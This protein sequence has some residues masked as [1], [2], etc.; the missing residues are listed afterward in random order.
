MTTV[1]E[2]NGSFAIHLLKTLCQNNPSKNVC[3]SPV[4]ISS[5][6]AMVL[7][8]AKGDTAA[9]ITQILGLNTEK[10]IHQGFQWLLNNLNKP[11]RKYI[12]RMANRIFAEV[13][14]ELPPAFKESCLQFYH[15]ET[16]QL[17]FVKAPEES[18]EHIN[19][20]V[21]K[22][23]E[24][25]IPELLSGD[26]IN[27]NTRMVLVNALYFK[28]R[29][30]QSFTKTLTKEMPFKINQKEKQPV[31]MMRQKDTFHLAYVNEVQAQVLLMPYEGMELS[32]VVLLP[33]DGVDLSKVENS[34]TFEKLTAWT[35]PYFMKSTDVEVFLPKFK[36]QEDYDMGSVLQRLTM[37]NVFQE[38]K[39]DLSGMSPEKDLCLSQ[40]IHKSVVE[41]NEEGT[42][43]AA[44]SATISVDCA[45][46]RHVSTFCAD[47]P[48]LFF[49]RHKETNSLLFC[50]R[51]SSP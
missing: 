35:R 17:S 40:F 47:H 7:L 30:Q 16:E 45:D 13:A 15:S 36:L 32:M 28:G 5:A 43:A 39:A 8:G 48:F 11:D 1:C 14:C 51:F 24:G 42:E 34:L 2:A 9:Q 37:M 6:L 25:K 41:V 12:L 44:A 10:D 4:S 38:D 22:Q 46:I 31:Q 20:W 29:W 26:S 27:S 49:I 18:R 3:Y 23:T 33:D 50:G 19:M 21:S